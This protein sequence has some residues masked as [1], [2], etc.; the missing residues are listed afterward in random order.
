MP[1]CQRRTKRDSGKPGQVYPERCRTIR[2]DF[3]IEKMSSVVSKYVVQKHNHAA[4]RE[5]G[6]REVGQ[7]SREHCRRHAAIKADAVGMCSRR[8]AAFEGRCTLPPLRKRVRA[9]AAGLASP[10]RA[11][12]RCLAADCA[13]TLA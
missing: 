5:A 6:G 7:T 3:T 2:V 4:A 9:A 11:A 10:Y 13:C 1:R 8:R 12:A